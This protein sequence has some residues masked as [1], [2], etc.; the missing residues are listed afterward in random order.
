MIITRRTALGAL[1]ASSL[2]TTVA[3]GF[4][5]ASAETDRRF[6]FIFLR[7]GMDSLTAVPA[8]GEPGFKALRGSLADGDPG[9][10]TSYDTLK[11]DGLFAMNPD[12]AFM[13]SLYTNGDLA[14]LHASC[15]GY[16][17]RSHFDAQDA[18][19]RG[20]VD[21]AMKSGWLNRMIAHLPG[22]MKTGR[23]TLVMGL[24][25]TLPLSLR[26]SEAVSSWSPPTAP[27]VSGDT[28]ERL[29]RLYAKD[30]VL[31]PA[32]EKGLSAQSMGEEM[33]MGSE[34]ANNFVLFAE[35]AARFLQPA[36]GARIATI[37]YGNWDSHADQNGRANV[38]TSAGTFHGRF[39]EMYLALDRGVKAFRDGMGDAWKDTVVI[40]LTEFGR[41]VRI[42]G[43]RGTDHGTGGA[44][45]VFGGAVKG[46]RVIADWPGLKESQLN[47]GRELKATIDNRAL[48]KAVMREHLGVPERA[49]ADIL[50]GSD[51]IAPL[52]GIVRST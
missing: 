10:G 47:D 28:M 32:L 12:L 25:P 39:A 18:F 5:L 15:H 51:G 23:E 42:N 2:L 20:T 37:D 43:T 17:D 48:L 45:F 6:L 22:G 24:G 46:G 33:G 27:K 8:Y 35:A 41:T 44:G 7:G 31:H 49:F 19:D 16:R 29:A 14:I 50:P 3:P 1:G 30:E 52:E 21:K 38:V 26:G 11:L 36:G 40:A 4:A 34:E 13:H 9:E